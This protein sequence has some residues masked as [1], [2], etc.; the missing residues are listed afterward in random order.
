MNKF[1]KF[2][3][4][5]YILYIVIYGF[6]FFNMMNNPENFN[7]IIPFHMFGMAL[8][9]AF[10]IIV[11]RDIFK[12]KFKNPNSKAIWA[13][14][15]I[16]FAPSILIYLPKYAFKPRDVAVESGN[17]TKYIIGLVAIVILFFGFIA[18]SMFTIPNKIQNQP[19]SLNTLAANGNNDK[20]LNRLDKGEISINDL[21]GSGNWSPLHSAAS[22]NK[23]KTVQFLIDRGVN[24]N[25]PCECNGDTPLHSAA[26]N[27]YYGV[28]KLLVEADADQTILNDKNKTA[29]DL[30]FEAGYGDTA[31]IL[32]N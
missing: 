21:N 30:A 8:G 7:R 19:E 13:T 24:I 28:V 17:D 25:Q 29:Y 23:I 32:N 14:L 6:F 20:I 3:S 31:N 12:R 11:V 27:G 10:L 22:N 5:F 4:I 9:L 15:L 18:Y 16:A 26:K 2:F 1:E